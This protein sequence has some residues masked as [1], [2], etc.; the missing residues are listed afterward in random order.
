MNIINHVEVWSYSSRDLN[1]VSRALE[2][3]VSYFLD[4]DISLN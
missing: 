4:S 3:L 1:F 2:T